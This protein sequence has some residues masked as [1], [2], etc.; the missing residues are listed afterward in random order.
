MLLSQV[1]SGQKK[2][3]QIEWCTGWTAVL[4]RI[5]SIPSSQGDFI[6]EDQ[7]YV[8]TVHK[9]RGG[10]R[11]TCRCDRNRRMAK[12]ILIKIFLESKVNGKYKVEYCGYFRNCRRG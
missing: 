6:L 2:I 7:H 5:K 1:C 4:C 8:E 3:N 10:F 12:K 11:C 9:D